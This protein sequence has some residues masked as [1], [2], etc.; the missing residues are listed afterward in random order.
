MQVQKAYA[1]SEK[2]SKFDASNA[3][4]ITWFMVPLAADP[5]KLHT[6]QLVLVTNSSISFFIAN[7]ERTDQLFVV[8]SKNDKL[9]IESYYK[10]EEKSEFY[11]SGSV[12]S[13]NCGTPGRWIFRV[14]GGGSSKGPGDSP[15]NDLLLK[16][17]NILFLQFKTFNILIRP[18]IKIFNLK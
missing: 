4:V 5:S 1:K 15:R 7:F 16:Q 8:D 13:T 14:D 2:F 9:P 6:F 18:S 12:T 3:F 11:F 17:F 10:D